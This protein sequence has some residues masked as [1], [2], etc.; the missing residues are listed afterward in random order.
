MFAVNNSLP[1]SELSK[2]AIKF[3]NDSDYFYHYMIEN[4]RDSV[5]RGPNLP[6]ATFYCLHHDL[7]VCLSQI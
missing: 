3:F 4:T 1:C 5:T 6:V 7:P 2:K